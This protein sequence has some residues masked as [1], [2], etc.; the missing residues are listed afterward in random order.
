MKLG[1]VYTHHIRGET[2]LRT[3]K[4]WRCLLPDESSV[5]MPMMRRMNAVTRR[6]SVINDMMVQKLKRPARQANREIVLYS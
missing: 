4:L 3:W 2:Q 1:H 6:P 5:T